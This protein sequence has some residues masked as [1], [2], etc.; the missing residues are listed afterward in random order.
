MEN[1][2]LITEVE[3]MHEIVRE[4]ELDALV[5]EVDGLRAEL[6]AQA[7][8]AAHPS[9]HPQVLILPLCPCSRPLQILLEICQGALAAACS[10]CQVYINLRD[11][12]NTVIEILPQHVYNTRQ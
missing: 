10:L 4:D 12:P 1:Q 7:D 8:Q 2:R 6:L 5:S 9:S 11:T 3:R